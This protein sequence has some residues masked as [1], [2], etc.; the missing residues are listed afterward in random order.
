VLLHT[1]QSTFQALVPWLLL[2]ATVLFAVSG[3][4]NKWLRRAAPVGSLQKKKAAFPIGIFVSLA[5]VSFYIGYFG[6]GA[7]FLVISVLSLSGVKSLNDVNALKV[8]CTSLANGVAV[9]TFI[10]A[11]AVY[12]GECLTMMGLATAGG[13]L[14]AAYSRKMN[15]AILR[16]A[17][18]ITGAALSL[19]F[20]YQRR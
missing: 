10:A 13:Y 16:G 17:V 12:W 8:L 18:I 19:Y 9:V 5:L 20:F 7:G 15:P 14:G 4:V 11:G 6:A 3:P 1:A 2:L